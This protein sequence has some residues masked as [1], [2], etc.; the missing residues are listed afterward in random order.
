MG[1]LRI[2]IVFF[3]H[4][5]VCLFSC[6]LSTAQEVDTTRSTPAADTLLAPAMP[7]RTD[8][9]AA[10]S[11]GESL[12]SWRPVSFLDATEGVLVTDVGEAVVG[13]T[14][15]ARHNALDPQGILGELPGAFVFDFGASGWPDGWSPYGLSPNSAVLTFNNI[16]Y[17][18]PSTGLPLYSLLP[19][20][21]LQ[22]LRVQPGRLGSAS[23]VNARL[24]SFAPARP[25][26]EIYYRSSNNGLQSAIINH[27]QN[28]S[29]RLF[30]QPAT[31]GILLAYGGHGA[32]GEYD[33]SRLS[34]ARQL[35]TRIRLQNEMGSLELLNLHNRRRLDAHAGIVPGPGSTR[36]I[37]IYNR[38]NATALDA[39]AERQVIRNDLALTVRTPLIGRSGSPLTL[40]GYWTANTFQYANVDTLRA[41]TNTFGYKVTQ[42]IRLNRGELALHVEGFTQQALENNRPSASALPDSLSLQRT[43]VHAYLHSRFDLGPV[44]VRIEPGFH[45]NSHHALWG[46]SFT[47][48]LVSSWAHVRLIASRSFE[49]FSF[50][51]EYGWGD[52]L[53][54][55]STVPS[56]TTHAARA[57]LGV[58]WKGVSLE[59]TA[60]A[61]QTENPVE[62]FAVD[63]D[64]VF[65][66]SLVEPVEWI[67]ASAELGLRK[68]ARRGLYLTLT[69][70]YYR[71]TS[72]SRSLEHAQIS[73][74]MPELFFRGRMGLRYVIFQG[75]L[76]FD[77]YAQGRLWSVFQSR[78]LHPETG[79]L[80]IRPLG[81]RPVDA[82]AAVD[83][84]LEAR[85][86]TAK[87]FLSLDNVLSGTSLIIGNMLVPNYPLPERRFRFGVHWPIWD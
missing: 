60:F 53:V 43:A 28:R 24:R 20:S 85:V 22:P 17:N 50:A 27:N 71:S 81:A 2:R 56:T 38:F 74:S 68:Y 78:T 62:Y 46:G 13:D 39:N 33:G 77:L 57:E 3:I 64:T 76:D 55:L 83:V 12:R 10:D 23:A 52:T 48:A 75:D 58:R 8:S 42:P 4:V 29:M 16:S 73:D 40:S 1:A 49:P 84:V 30:R 35:L 69:P 63:E 9:L 34:A 5:A 44:R 61:H 51:D 36:F 79:L 54:P 15:P 25:L 6:Q 26:T 19:L 7:Q 67:G 14:L 11:S 31:L 82:A 45:K 37:D 80:V 87:I 41:K 86:R 65:V 66:R 32:R 21:L 18:D 59:A 47:L 72:S 70:A